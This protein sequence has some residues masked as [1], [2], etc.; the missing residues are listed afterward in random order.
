MATM[1]TDMIAE[2][3]KT[4]PDFILGKIIDILDSYEK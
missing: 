4:I 2:R 1:T 3:M